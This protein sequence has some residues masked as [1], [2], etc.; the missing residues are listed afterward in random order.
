MNI[1]AVTNRIDISETTP[2]A[3]AMTKEYNI[4]FGNESIVATEQPNGLTTISYR[5][6]D[7]M[8]RDFAARI[9]REESNIADVIIALEDRYG[10]D[11]VKV[12]RI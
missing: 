12:T 6:T 11:G 10:E 5:G 9:N 2:K 4:E 1:I 8:I 7:T 3:P